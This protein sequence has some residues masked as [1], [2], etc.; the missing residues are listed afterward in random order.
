MEGYE[1]LRK[2]RQRRD[3]EAGLPRVT[4]QLEFM[5]PHLGMGEELTEMG[6]DSRQARDR[7]LYSGG[8]LQSAAD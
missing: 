6:Q 5:E 8:V 3:E 4:D 7:G 2:V 1:F